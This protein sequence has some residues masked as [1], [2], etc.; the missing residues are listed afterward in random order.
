M[1]DAAL[2]QDFKANPPKI[3][4]YLKVPTSHGAEL[5]RDVMHPEQRRLFDALDKVF[6]PVCKGQRSEPDQIKVWAEMTKGWGKTT[7]VG[8]EYIMLLALAPEELRSISG[9]SDLDQSREAQRAIATICRMNPFLDGTLDVQNLAIVNPHTHSRL[10][11]TPSDSSSAHGTRPNGVTHVDE[12]GNIPE[13]RWDCVLTWLNN[14]SKCGG[15]T[16]LTTNAGF[17]DHPAWKLR[18]F[19]RTSPRWEFFQETSV[20]PH[21]PPEEIEE[22]R[23]RNPASVFARYFEGIW[24]DG[25]GD[26]LDP[27]DI[28]AAV[29]QAGPM[30]GTEPGF[31][32]VGGLDLASRRDHASLV[33][34]ASHFAT[35][36]VRLARCQSWAPVAGK[37]DLDAV[38][39]AVAAANVQYRL[40]AVHYDPHEASLMVSDLT[41]H[42]PGVQAVQMEQMTFSGA[43]LN[44]M[45]SEL[46]QA[47]RDRRIDLYDDAALL[48]DLRRLKIVERSY[49]VRLDATRDQHGHIDAATAFAVALPAALELCERPIVQQ[50][51][52]RSSISVFKP[53]A[54]PSYLPGRGPVGYPK[55]SNWIRKTT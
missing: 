30:D 50:F 48:R 42:E 8:I 46:L 16:C 34:L 24:S 25:R 28:A 43:N 20:P 22:A 51:V 41:R 5:L 53:G 21:I 47:F 1:I 6:V 36:R 35:K 27:A 2:L 7:S 11:F 40:Q 37:V 10:D 39:T 4:D 23:A 19:A 32:F 31:Q 45:A 18:E 12:A 44:R 14:A 26:A 15:A 54:R 55:G 17:M 13:S 38:R 49:G 29:T 33:I 9:A 52:N 3:R